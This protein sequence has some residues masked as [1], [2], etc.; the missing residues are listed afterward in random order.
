MRRS[1]IGLAFASPLA[2]FLAV[3]APAVG[4]GFISDDFRWIRES[5]LSALSDVGALFQGS[6]GFYRPI[7]ALSFGV[8]HFLFGATPGPYGVVNLGL[9]LVCAGLALLVYRR[10]GLTTG[11]ACLGVAIWL[12]NVHGIN[13]ALLWIS[14]RTAL[15]LVASS[16]AAA[17]AL[18]SH[19]PLA[20]I[21]FVALA[22]FSKEEA[23]MLPFVLLAWA[24]IVGEHQTPAGRRRMAVL[25]LG[26][27]L[28]LLLYAILR[29]R[30]GAMT[31]STAPDFY[32]F[33][34][35]PRQVLRNAAEYF[36]RACSFAMGVM[37]LAVVL[38]RTPSTR[39][40]LR[41]EPVLA[42]VAWYVGGYAIT[43]FLPVRSSLYSCVPA[44]AAALI[45]AEL[46]SSL[47]AQAD[48]RR[49]RNALIAVAL[50]PILCLPIYRVRNRRWTDLARFSARVL[51]DLRPHIARMSD[52]TWLV[53]VD[54]RSQRVNLQSAF[55]A[56]LPDALFL[57]AQRPIKVWVESAAGPGAGLPC[58][59]CPQVRLAVTSGGLVAAPP[60]ER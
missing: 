22:L 7:V 25:I 3:Y 51:D 21:L 59:D 23:V 43:T 5:R 14:G 9:A 24:A 36:D 8:N 15:L 29:H 49:R 46:G 40:R 60:S 58:V 45:A 47:W 10:L 2:V 48:D 35:D 39:I 32:R 54:D 37:L 53:L 26:F 57:V 44:V 31:A 55:G 52:N 41:R 13:M 38:L 12:L 33:T 18:L 19:R 56:L 27:A 42:A 20:A 34:V 16:L 4:Q 30:S 11:A 28:D 6:N 1:L 17:L 50:V